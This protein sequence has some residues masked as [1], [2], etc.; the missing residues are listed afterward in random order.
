[1]LESNYIEKLIGIKDVILENVEEINYEK[2]IYF[3]LR[4]QIHICPNCCSE[5]NT[6]HDYR[7]QVVKDCS[8]YGAKTYLH[9]RKR[10]YVCGNC[11]KRF[12][13]KNSF[14]PKYQRTT[15]RLWA[16]TLNSLSD[17]KSMK[18]VAKEN[19]I[20]GTSVARIFDNV[21][22]GLPKLPSIISID[23]FRGNSGGEK[24]NCIL[25]NPSKKEILDIMPKR[26]T[27]DLLQYFGQFDNR[28]TVKI[29]SMDMSPLFR[30]VARLSFPNADIVADKFHVARQVTWAFENVRKRVQKDLGK[31]SR[32]RLKNAR[33]LLLKRSENLTEEEKH[34][35]ATYLEYRKELGKAY[36]LKEAFN[37]VL[38][39][40][41]EKEAE[42]MLKEWMLHV[43]I[44]N[45]KEFNHCI[46]TFTEWKQ[47]I[48]NAFKY[49]ISNGY[50]EGCNNLIK[51]IKRTG[52]GL[53]NFERFRNRILY[54]SKSS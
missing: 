5:T 27:N 48:L 15:Q 23:E 45:L 21:S 52:Y 2:H 20:S 54:I 34:S 51:V 16:N 30:Y 42:R 1:M 46:K 17:V 31:A 53:R 19:N 11:G 22:Y 41:D 47:E 38:D 7:V 3:T 36:Y 9:F 14:L 25:T 37:K 6:I 4:R 8:S 32:I 28:N 35:V 12:F 39:S 49:H 13:E 43:Q 26:R 44:A 50:T 10:R 29:V 33:K 24:F 40:K 18:Q